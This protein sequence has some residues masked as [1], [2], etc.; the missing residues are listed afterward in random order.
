MR[1]AAILLAGVMLAAMPAM[2]AAQTDDETSPNNPLGLAN[3]VKVLAPRDP[4]VRKATAIVNGA[5]ITDTDV[6]QRLALVLASSG[7]RINEEERARLRVQVLSNLID[8]TLQIQEAAAN[9]I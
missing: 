8:E 6:D 2:T 4:S 7:G 1:R 3:D 9:K 5:I